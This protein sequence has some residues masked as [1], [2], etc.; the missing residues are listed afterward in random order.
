MA[1][2]C[3]EDGYIPYTQILVGEQDSLREEV[4]WWSEDEME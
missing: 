1:G 3:G 2:S 4:S